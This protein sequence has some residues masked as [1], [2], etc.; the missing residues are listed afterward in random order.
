MNINKR[1]LAVTVLAAVWLLPAAAAL[2]E[3]HVI[4]PF[5][6]FKGWQTMTAYVLIPT[7]TLVTFYDPHSGQSYTVQ[8]HGGQEYRINVSSVPVFAASYVEFV[9]S[10]SD[11]F[12]PD[13]DNVILTEIFAYDQQPG[14]D[15]NLVPNLRGFTSSQIEP[16]GPAHHIGHSGTTYYSSWYQTCTMTQLPT[17]F[18]GYD[19]SK[20]GGVASNVVHC[21][22]TTVPAND[23]VPQFQFTYE[24]QGMAEVGGEY[25]YQHSWVLNVTQWNSSVPYVNDIHVEA[26][27]I[28]PGYVTV[29]PPPNWSILPITIG[30]YGYQANPG[31]EFTNVGAYTDW[32]VY[33]K[34]PYVVPGVAYLTKNGSS[35]SAQVATQVPARDFEYNA[36]YLGYENVGG[37]FPYRHNYQFTISQFSPDVSYVNNYE[38]EAPYIIPGYVEV[39]PPSNWHQSDPWVAGRIG[40]EANPGHEIT[41]GGGAFGWS[42]S[43]KTPYVV[44]G[45]FY[46]TKGNQQVSH[47]AAVSLPGPKIEFTFE[48]QPPTYVGGDYPYQHT[49]VLNV[50][51]CELGQAKISDLEVEGPHVVPGYV[52]VIPP[53]NWIVGPWFFGRYGYEA[54]TGAEITNAGAYTGWTV[55]AKTPYVEPGYVWLT[56]SG[57]PL[58]ARIPTEVVSA[59]PECGAQG[60]LE[61]DVNH[62]CRTDLKDLALMSNQWLECTLPGDPDCDVAPPTV[63]GI[64]F[65]FNGDSSEEAKVLFLYDDL[66]TGVLEAG[67]TIVA[68]QGT[69]V[70]SGQELES[71]IE[72]LPDLTVGAP[73]SLTV[74][75]AGQELPVVATALKI[76]A[77]RTTITDCSNKRCARIQF[78]GGGSLQDQYFCDC[79]TQAPT[80]AWCNRIQIFHR[81]GG[82]LIG[83]YSWCRDAAGNTCFEIAT[84]K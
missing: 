21:S 10:G 14:L 72:S 81:R 70:S 16:L 23:F 44:P 27:Y 65:A 28:I 49:W 12:D 11:P 19:L 52:E 77:E 18:P 22:K 25:P 39:T 8:S 33:G 17:Y 29:V 32:N 51:Q 47:V 80:T 20:F 35:V 76:A 42:L 71:V 58:S 59:P 37:A 13:T 2:A 40:F 64:G 55:N 41:A 3:T 5:P 82:K 78:S 36:E 75:R 66:N 31:A 84:A 83:V 48:H 34:T 69:P 56:D 63:I 67:D 1:W 30:R 62:D 57:S 73:V 60:Y 74:R 6:N 45:T 26:P 79:V 4:G 50:T 54:N 7:T 38:L 46:L 24:Y 43:A 53:T 15:P 68:Y 9:S 61:A